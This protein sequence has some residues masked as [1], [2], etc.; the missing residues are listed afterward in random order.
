MTAIDIRGISKRFAQVT[1]ADDINLQIS[2][3]ERLVF[4]GRSG[5]GKTTL[6]RLIAGLETPDSG[7]VLRDGQDILKSSPATRNVALVSQDYALYPQLSVEQNLAASLANSKLTAAD[8]K[9]RIAET[10]SWFE[11]DD[12]RSRLPSQLSGGQAQRAAFARAVVRRPAILLLDEPLSQVDTVLKHE[13]RELILSL[14]RRFETT[15]IMVTHD[16]LDAMQL[17]TRI[18]TIDQGKL[19]QV[20]PPH[21]VYHHPSCRVSAELLSPFGVNWISA[22]QADTWKMQRPS[23][24]ARNLLGLR[25]EHIFAHNTN[26]CCTEHF[27]LQATIADIR[28]LG[29]ASLASAT[30]DRALLRVLDMQ[31]QL[32]LGPATLCIPE[33]N[34]LWLTTATNINCD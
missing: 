18:V 19:L 32:K 8:Q 30:V 3:G 34:C 22:E 6:L 9:Q 21:E 17:A 31:H 27:Q 14:S 25:P 23:E 20:G 15:I 7:C 10:L 11:I 16:P 4:L 2:A 24:P 26:S 5:A 28:Y 29:F 12:L 13:C 33:T 1:A